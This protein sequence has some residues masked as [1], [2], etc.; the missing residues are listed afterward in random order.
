M[1]DTLFSNITNSTDSVGDILTS[2]ANS[3]SKGKPADNAFNE[4]GLI[5]YLN[6]HCKDVDDH[7][8]VIEE[9]IEKD[10]NMTVDFVNPND[11]LNTTQNE[12]LGKAYFEA[13]LLTGS[14]SISDVEL[15]KNS[16]DKKII[17]LVTAREDNLDKSMV[18]IMAMNLWATAP[19]VKA[20]FTLN[21]I[22]SAS[23]PARENLG[24]IDV[25]SNS[26]WKSIT[27]TVGSLSAG[28]IGI[29]S[30]FVK[31]I[32]PSSGMA[33][34]DLAVT[35]ASIFTNFEDLLFNQVRLADSEMAKFGFK[36]LKYNNTLFMYDE[37]CPTG[38][39]AYINTK[40][41]KLKVYKKINMVA[42]DYARP[43]NQLLRTRNKAIYYQLT[44]NKRKAHGLQS[45]VIE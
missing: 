25:D 28:G 27:E 34:P 6:D 42:S 30:S 23:D 39:I 26:W 40:F 8:A 14:V 11:V 20:P 36:T 24:R 22:I 16:G 13:K 35:T 37:F 21:E 18:R 17:D 44:T 9:N 45:G 10:V 19:S 31:Q 38:Y 7:G 1:A 41:L 12:I 29:V 2:T 43:V 5:K 15:A 3:V 4:Y 32:A 33:E